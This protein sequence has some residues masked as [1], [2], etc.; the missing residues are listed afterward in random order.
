MRKVKK[1]NIR[2]QSCPEIKSKPEEPPIQDPISLDEHAG[3]VRLVYHKARLTR[4][5][6]DIP[7]TSLRGVARDIL[8]S[9]RICMHANRFIAMAKIGT[10]PR[11][12]P[13]ELPK[14]TRGVGLG[15]EPS[16]PYRAELDDDW[17]CLMADLTP[18]TPLTPW[19]NKQAYVCPT[20]QANGK[21]NVTAM[22]ADVQEEVEHRMAEVREE[23]EEEEDDDTERN[24]ESGTRGRLG[25]SE[26]KQSTL[27]VT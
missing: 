10:K 1:M 3:F 7:Y 17:K 26:N 15:A 12:L 13:K 19:G 23:E 5:E 4:M 8:H 18:M 11:D 27:I 16:T 22:N 24:A 25:L 14:F 21:A 6:R 9:V 2:R 20:K